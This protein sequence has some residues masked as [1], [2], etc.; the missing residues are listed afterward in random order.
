VS[1]TGATGAI[2]APSQA[3]VDL[4]TGRVTTPWFRFF[5]QLRAAIGGAGTTGATGATGA[6]GATGASGVGNAGASGATGPTGATGAGGGG[7]ATGATGATGPTGATGIAA[8]A[9]APLVL[10]AGTLSLNYGT[11]LGV[12]SDTLD[13]T[14]A[15]TAALGGVIIGTTGIHVSGGTISQIAGSNV[16]YSGTDNGTI[17]VSIGSGGTVVAMGTNT[18]L[19]GNINYTLSAS[20]LPALSA[21]DILRIA[22][23]QAHTSADNT[24]MALVHNSG[25]TGY[26]VRW[27]NNSTV[28]IYRITGTASVSSMFTAGSGNPS[29]TVGGKFFLEVVVKDTLTSQNTILGGVV[30]RSSGGAQGNDS[31]VDLTTA[32]AWYL[33]VAD[34][35][36][37]ATVY[38]AT[39]WHNAVVPY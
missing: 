22:V 30:G 31:T 7:G 38:G 21:G 28:D 19:A 15:T 33:G 5:N 12:T 8:G 9:S 37:T 24:S 6:D 2:I 20:A 25:T 26:E 3:L 27:Q 11:G 18:L 16:T 32:G 17:N 4:S 1:G 36:G 34:Q 39:Q 13:V 29:G 14:A 23:V 35:S 10:S